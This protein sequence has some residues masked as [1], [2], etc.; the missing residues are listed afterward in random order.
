MIL[1]NFAGGKEDGERRG[2][3]AGSLTHQ[4]LD[5]GKHGGFIGRNI[6][7]KE[8]EVAGFPIAG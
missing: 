6:T 2:V 1:V 4:W 5:F 7:D 3:T 8:E